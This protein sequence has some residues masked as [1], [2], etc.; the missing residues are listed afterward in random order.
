MGECR[1]RSLARVRA[2]A[3]FQAETTVERSDA[4]PAGVSA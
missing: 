1:V 2:E 4:G 3:E